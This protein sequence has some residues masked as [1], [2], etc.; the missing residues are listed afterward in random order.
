MNELMLKIYS[1][2]TTQIY[3]AAGELLNAMGLYFQTCYPGGLYLA[4]GMFIPRD[5]TDWWEVKGT[6]RCEI[7]NGLEVV[8][9]GYC[10]SLTDRMNES[11]FGVDVEFVGGWAWH[12]MNYPIRKR[13]A[14]NRVEEIVWQYQTGASAADKCSLQRDQRLYFLPKAEAWGNGEFAT[15]GYNMAFDKIARVTYDMELEPGAQTWSISLY[16]S[17]DGISYT[18]MTGASGETYNAGT[19]TV[20]TASTA[21]TPVSID[22]EPAS[23]TK[24]LAFTYA[25]GAGQ[26]PTSD[27]T[28]FAKITN[29]VVFSEDEGITPGINL[30]SVAADI[31]STMSTANLLNSDT[32]QI[33]T[34][35]TVRKVEPFMTSGDGYEVAA[36]ILAGLQGWGDGDNNSWAVQLLA[37]R[38]AT[39][40]NG[41]PVLSVQQYPDVDAGYD[42]FLS[43]E[44]PR[45]V[46]GLSITEDF[47]DY[48]RNYAIVCYR[49]ENGFL[50]FVTPADDA[51]LTDATSVAAYGT[52]Y[53]PLVVGTSTQQNAIDYGARFIAAYKDPL[54]LVDDITILGYLEDANGQPIPACRVQA[55]KRLKI[56][57]YDTLIIMATEY[58][59]EAQTVRITVGQQEDPVFIESVFAPTWNDPIPGGDAA[60]SGGGRGGSQPWW[61]IL[62][63]IGPRG[64]QKLK[65]A[66]KWEEYKKAG[67]Q[68]YRELRK[69]RGKG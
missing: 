4:A 49:D 43:P 41:R 8:F 17:A 55:G 52:R 10:G 29:L 32:S 21:G 46:G 3:D 57:G 44:N 59:H 13:W 64:R 47:R 62:D 65:A 54:N 40:P 53:A 9:E 66:G 38:K 5:P 24:Y 48:L 6:L 39:T 35:S 68:R 12:L 30:A 63:E 28:Y 33:A 51:S 14:D 26:T 19:T 58:D 18:Q 69:R 1:S 2:G 15:V 34:A 61:K 50:Q 42:Y 60:M 45:I 31:V 27:G 20:Q 16:R 37:S 7:L 56:D 22:V 11:E 25:A 36:S 23:G 67:M